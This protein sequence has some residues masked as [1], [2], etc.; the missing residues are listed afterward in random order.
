MMAS[1]DNIE[2]IKVILSKAAFNEH[3]ANSTAS[4]G[5]PCESHLIHTM[6]L[7]TSAEEAPNG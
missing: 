4:P 5:N 2:I 1:L 6:I 3:E 7:P